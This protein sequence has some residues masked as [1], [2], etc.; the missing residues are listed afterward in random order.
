MPTAA[1]R[2][3]PATV[4][5]A[6]PRFSPRDRSADAGTTLEIETTAGL[7]RLELLG[8]EAGRPLF[9]ADMGRPAD[10]REAV[11]DAGGERVTA[12]VLNMGN[13]QC[14]VLG[15][16]PEAARFARLGPALERHPAFPDGTN[17]EFAH[18]ETPG[19]VRMVIWERGVGPTA[20]SGTGSCAAAVAAAAHGGASRSVEVVAPGGTQHVEWTDDGVR[21]TG[22]AE[23]IADGSCYWGRDEFQ[24]LPTS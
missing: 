9:A 17:V 24:I 8:L 1:P 11:L 3:S 4:C 10:I 12:T 6:W 13:P 22:W 15:P 14:V 21:L 5:A 2:S 19:R 20:S 23:I 18:V 7:K 16:L